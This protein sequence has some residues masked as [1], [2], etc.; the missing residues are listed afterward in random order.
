MIHEY[1]QSEQA[2]GGSARAHPFVSQASTAQCPAYADAAKRARGATV[3][4]S[5]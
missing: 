1:E 3:A 4:A 5:R 2:G